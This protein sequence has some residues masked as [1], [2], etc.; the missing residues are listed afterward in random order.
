V[1]VVEEVAVNVLVLVIVVVE[2][3]VVVMVVDVRVVVVVVVVV[4][5][6]VVVLVVMGYCKTWP[7]PQHPPSKRSMTPSPSQSHTSGTVHSQF[8]SVVI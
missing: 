5:V 2:A 7:L 3:V 8:S 1:V 4:A 6:V